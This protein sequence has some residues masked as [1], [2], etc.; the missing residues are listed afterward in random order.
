MPLSTD[1]ERQQHKRG[2]HQRLVIFF[3]VVFAFGLISV[4][5][6]IQQHQT[7][8]QQRQIAA[9]NVRLADTQ[10]RECLLRN[11]SAKNLNGI[12]DAIIVAV[13]TTKGLPE[14]EK[15]KRIGYYQRAKSRFF[16]CGQDPT[17]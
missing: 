15:T 5:T 17:P 2:Y 11:E 4:R 1:E 10:Y 8:V 3:V 6:E 13:K 14:A 7:N 9:T 16:D 12:L